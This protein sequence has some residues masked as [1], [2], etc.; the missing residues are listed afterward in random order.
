MLFDSIVWKRPASGILQEETAMKRVSGLV[1]LLS[2]AAITPALAAGY[3]LKEQSAQAMGS[4]YAGVAADLSNPGA[5]SYNPAT[6][7]GVVDTDV[8][9]SL[10]EIVPHSSAVYGTATTSA[11][12]PAGGN[13]AP[14]NF[15]GDAPVPDVVLRH[16]LSDRLS[17]GLGVSVPFGLKTVFPTGWAG[18]Y[19]ARKTSAITVNVAPSLAWQATPE[20]TLGASLNI[21]YARGELTSAI[22][23]GTLGV[24][25]AM[26]GAMPGALDSGAR[27][28][29]ISWSE[30]FS[31]GAVW[32]PMSDLGF[33]LAYKSAISHKM[34]GPLTFTLDGA[35]LGA[36]IRGATGLFTDT[37]ASVKLP[38]P[39]MILF[40]AKKQLSDDLAVMVELDW[41]NWSR[42]KE[43]TVVARNP[44][45]PDDVTLA[46]WHDSIFASLGGEYRLND[47]WKLRAGVGYDESPVP[48]ATRGPRIPD[49]NRTWLAAG[50]EYRLASGAALNLSYGHLFNDD[51]NIALNAAQTGNALRGNLAGVT[52]SSVDTLGLQ[53]SSAL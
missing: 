11:G 29:A 31:L 39:D 40:G 32:Q 7:A 13:A 2:M 16:R 1:L 17:V 44:A 18:R 51:Q 53:V 4:A 21:E 12:T 49:A 6:L 30:G 37:R 19:Y 24:L 10:V 28:S 45:Q 48:D 33:G 36:A 23:T 14:R 9:F 42:F 38:M 46:N 26:P 22:D 27:L 41:T 5:L 50:M 20:L 15:I 52:R 34:S 3:G 47:A 25:S 43:L 8:A 35:G